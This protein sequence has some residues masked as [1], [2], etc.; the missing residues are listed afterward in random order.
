MRRVI[1][2]L[3]IYFIS[4]KTH[5]QVVWNLDSC[6]Q[7]A[8]QNNTS[9]LQASLRIRAVR[10]Q[11]QQSSARRVPSLSFDNNIGW[12]GGRSIDPTLNTYTNTN[13]VFQNLGLQSGIT[14]FNWFSIS[15]TILAEK[16]NVE[17]SVLDLEK[18][19][20]DISLNIAAAYLQVLLSNEKI[21]ISKK[22]IQLTS[23]Q[24]E[25]TQLLFN[26]GRQT[27]AN[28]LQLQAQLSRDSTI[29]F[30]S[31]LNDYQSNANLLKLLGIGP[32]QQI[33]ISREVPE[34]SILNI[35][36]MQPETIYQIA[37]TNQ[38]L[39]KEN[40][41][42][43]K[44]FEYRI[45][46]AKAAQYPTLSANAGIG[47]NFANTFRDALGRPI[48]YG[49]QLFNNNFQQSFYL[50]LNVP[51]FYNK[52]LKTNYKLAQSEYNNQQLTIVNNNLELKHKIYAAY[53]NVLNSWNRYQ[54]MKNSLSQLQE[55]FELEK[56]SFNTGN[57]P[58]VSFLNLGNTLFQA[59][60]DKITSY[61][62]YIFSMRILEHYQKIN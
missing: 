50:S 48:P 57:T 24:L 30:D 19:K 39:Q 32:E 49:Q 40:A 29:Y 27:Q 38:P 35:M 62:E 33:K 13:L 43:L 21:E 61:Y 4:V 56:I 51:I 28:V 23:G 17:S 54:S 5:G 2:F 9:I 1:L 34:K 7:Y 52:Q 58:L 45:K 15:N 59:Q 6:V 16:K 36:E 25:T 53:K 10:A 31:M 8:T 41:V 22:Q 55:A 26:Q 42:K 18:L 11:M 37:L 47:S 44:E 46:A 20:N 12:Q 3:T 14:L 60:T